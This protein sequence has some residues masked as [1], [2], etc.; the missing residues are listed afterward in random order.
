MTNWHQENVQDEP[1]VTATTYDMLVVFNT[2]M[3]DA[4]D[5]LTKQGMPAVIVG[6]TNSIIMRLTEN[7]RL[8]LWE[9]GIALK[10]PPYEFGLTKGDI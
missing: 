10:Y 7:Q 9:A 6:T 1:N 8:L 5:V 2:Q 3:L 4:I